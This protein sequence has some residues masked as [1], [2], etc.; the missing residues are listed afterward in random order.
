MSH[1]KLYLIYGP[2]AV[3]KTT[4]ARYLATKHGGIHIQLDWFSSMQRGR[5]WY[6]RKNNRDKMNIL[7]GTLHA[8]FNKTSYKQ[9]Y[10]DGVL[11][12][13]FMFK[14]LN[15]WCAKNKI[16]LIPIKLIGDESELNKRINIR[17]KAVKN[18]NKLLPKI[19]RKFLYKGSRIINTSNL[20][21]REVVRKVDNSNQI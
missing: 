2:N 5:A 1:K 7:I 13:K 8:I 21:I 3:G 14:I 16:Q 15:G 17:K 19:Y 6:T 20:N 4:V 11:I 18:I 10:I 9:V 12:Y